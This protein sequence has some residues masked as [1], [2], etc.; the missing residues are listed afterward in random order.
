MKARVNRERLRKAFEGSGVSQAKVA[1]QLGVSKQL[2]THWIQG[3][4]DPSEAQLKKLAGLI[5]VDTNFLTGA[6]DEDPSGGA[7]LDTLGDAVWDFRK[8]PEDGGRDYG[9]ANVLAFTPDIDTLVRELGQNALDQLLRSAG[10]MHLRFSLMELTVSSPAYAAFMDAMK[11]EELEPHIKAAIELNSRLSSKLRRGLA[12]IRRLRVLRVE[13]FGTTGAYGGETTATERGEK[14]PFAA[15]MRDNLNSSK[16][17]NIA[18]GT[19]GAGKATA[20]QCSDIGTVLLSSRIAASLALPEQP[21]DALRFIAKAEL[22]WHSWHEGA[23][24]GP[25]WLS[26]PEHTRSIWLPP[27]ELSDLFLDRADLPKGVDESARSGTSLAIVGFRDP[28]DDRESDPAAI[29]DRIKRAVAENFFPAI[30]EGRMAV[31]VEHHVDGEPK[32]TD[33]VDPKEY[34]PEMVVAYEA[35]RDDELTPHERAVAGDT[36]HAH[37]IHP[38]PR[39]RPDAAPTLKR[40]EEDLDAT[41]DLIVRFAKG[42]E[43]GPTGSG[44]RQLVNHVALVRGRRMVVEYLRRSNIVVGGRAFHGI[45]LAG[46]AVGEQ[47][48]QA[49]AEQFFRLAEPPAHNKWIWREDVRDNYRTGAKGDLSTFYELL[50]EKL[51]DLIKPEEEAEDDG[52]DE[53]RKLLFLAGPARPSVPAVIRINEQTLKDGKWRISAEVAINDR[54]RFLVLR[55]S[56]S[57]QPESG[58]TVD[59]EWEELTVTRATKGDAKAT[60]E[61]EIEAPAGT[62]RVFFDAVTRV[63]TDGLDLS[64][65]KVTVRVTAR[66]GTAPAQVATAAQGEG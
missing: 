65:C 45:L 58:T 54:K 41:A 12:G 6:I 60:P 10:S 56:I 8:A 44:R 61:L 15:L 5:A 47:P 33:V 39:T 21:E 50:N 32:K 18:G 62:A 29:L 27:A 52:P 22:T 31:S 38:V 59:L 20:W 53:L 9:N 63:R 55:P 24:A 11:W 28:Q 64:R 66:P 34:V 46:E 25:G 26:Y 40:F 17:T 48:A 3:R 36:T 13:D 35:H 4:R 42:E 43:L 19:H 16:E 2:V 49:A 14:S 57:V 7:G 23:R 30:L 1:E 37:L 51:R